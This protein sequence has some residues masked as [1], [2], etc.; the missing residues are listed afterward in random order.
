MAGESAP[1]A[2]TVHGLRGVG[3]GVASGPRLTVIYVV[4]TPDGLLLAREVAGDVG[5]D[6]WGSPYQHDLWAAVH[7]DVDPHRGEVNGLPLVQDMRAK[8]P[9]A[10]QR[11][12]QLYRPNPIASAVLTTLGCP[13]RACGGTIA[14]VGREDDEGITTTLTAAQRHLV[15]TAHRFARTAS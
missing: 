2:Q 4:V 12:P 13:P 3:A 8:V 15:A 1:T 7:R 5:V 10:A 9:D 6:D 11:L 14:I